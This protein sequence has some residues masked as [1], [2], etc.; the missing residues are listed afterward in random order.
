MCGRAGLQTSKQRT[1]RGPRRPAK[2]PGQLGQRPIM[3]QR[4]GGCRSPR[5]S[6]HLIKVRGNELPRSLSPGA[7]R[8]VKKSLILPGRFHHA[9]RDAGATLTRKQDWGPKKYC[10][11]RPISQK[12]KL[13]HRGASHSSKV[14]V[15]AKL[16]QRPASLLALKTKCVL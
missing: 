10:Y 4:R 15:T 2:G 9:K 8:K 14:R 5:P 12:K 6:S 11:R 13:R 3:T 1:P 7:G 16:G